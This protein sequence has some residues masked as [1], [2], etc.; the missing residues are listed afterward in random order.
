MTV[1]KDHTESICVQYKGNRS[2]A[3]FLPSPN[4]SMHEEKVVIMLKAADSTGIKM[5]FHAVQNWSL[6]LISTGCC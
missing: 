3:S 5:I 4:I 2:R 1:K 6:K